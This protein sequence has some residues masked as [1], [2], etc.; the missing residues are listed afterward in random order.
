MTWAIPLILLGLLLALGLAAALVAWRRARELRQLSHVGIGLPTLDVSA[1]W[2]RQIR[3]I[4]LWLGLLCTVVA[5]GGPRWGAD[6]TD[7]QVQGIDVLIAMDCSR[8]MLATDLFP[9]RSRAA[10]NKSIDLLAHLGDAR[11]SLLPFAAVATL[12]CPL[13]SDHVAAARMLDDCTPD[14]FPARAGL[15]GTAIGRAVTTGVDILGRDGGRGQAI[16]VVSD[17]SDNDK[18]AVTAAAALAK[19]SGIP[20]YGL[21]VGDSGRG[22]TIHVDGKDVSVPGERTTLDELAA[23]TGGICVNYSTTDDDVAQLAAHL[24]DHIQRA[25]WDE[26]RQVVQSERYRWPLIPGIACLVI[27]MFIP[28]A[29]RRKTT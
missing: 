11:V 16:L 19:K 22:A 26:R 24:L 2:R 23:A 9:D 29:G 10:R 12:R 3:Q 15:Q 1:P 20:V 8:S 18:E 21:F 27:A 6:E 14:L 17:G 28:T 5:I 25:P 13:T 4:C 7:R